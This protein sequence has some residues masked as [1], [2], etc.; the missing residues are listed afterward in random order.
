MFNTMWQRTRNH[1]YSLRH[2]FSE[3]ERQALR[4]RR[5]VPKGSY[6]P[7]EHGKEWAAGTIHT[8]LPMVFYLNR[9]YADAAISLL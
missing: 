5:G 7:G 1:L 2:P 9:Q 8:K 4:L 6:V 3:T